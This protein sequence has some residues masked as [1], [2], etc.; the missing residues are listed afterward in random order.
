M[1]YD[2]H[3]IVVHFPVAL[4]TLYSLMCV[5]P[6]SRWFSAMNWKHIRVVFLSVGVVG[7]IVAIITGKIAEKISAP[8]EDIVELHTFFALVTVV[9]YG[10]LL[11]GDGVFTW[12]FGEK[13]QIPLLLSLQSVLGQRI[14]KIVL[15]IIALSTLTITGMLGGVM[16]YGTISDP[17]AAPVLKLLEYMF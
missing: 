4:L 2:L 11:V 9:T 16:V 8:M 14:I 12:L 6:L 13:R 3:P 10:L 5:L 17:L 1:A 7:G 15:A